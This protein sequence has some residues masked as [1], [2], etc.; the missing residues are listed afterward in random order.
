MAD[1]I[2]CETMA[3]IV[4]H[5]RYIGDG[6]LPVNYG[7]HWPRPITLCGREAS[8]DTRIPPTERSITCRRCRVVMGWPEML[9][10]HRR[11]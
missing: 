5:L 6:F 4:H 11:G 3:Y 2:A 1:V 10:D 8:W 9:E 7:G